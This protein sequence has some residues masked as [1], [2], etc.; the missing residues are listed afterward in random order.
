[1]K[2][3]SGMCSGTEKILLSSTK[4]KLRSNSLADIKSIIRQ[5]STIK[6]ARED[7]EEDREEK[8][9]EKLNSLTKIMDKLVNVLRETT[10]TSKDIN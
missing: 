7:S 2:K 8:F 5:S 3:S 4:N 9:A 10:N 6:R 1:M